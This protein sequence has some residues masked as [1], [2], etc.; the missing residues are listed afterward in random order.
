L[1]EN[2]EKLKVKLLKEGKLKI[3]ILKRR[4]PLKS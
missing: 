3:Y 2:E 1:I 4:F